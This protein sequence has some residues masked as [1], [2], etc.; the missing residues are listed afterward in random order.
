MAAD[1][2]TQMEAL[3][4]D[5]LGEAHVL[6]QQLQASSEQLERASTQLESAEQSLRRLLAEAGPDLRRQ[7]EAAMR[8]ANGQA[9]RAARDVLT[10]CRGFQHTTRKLWSAILL[11]AGLTGLAAGCLG[12]ALTTLLR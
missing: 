4:R 7:C 11:A 10:A 8:D 9:E 1:P 3:Y 2:R 5:V 6:V 12:V